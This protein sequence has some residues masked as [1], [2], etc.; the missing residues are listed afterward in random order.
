MKN[1]SIEQLHAEVSTAQKQALKDPYRYERTSEGLVEKG[2]PL[3]NSGKKT[4]PAAVRDLVN[5][6]FDKFPHQL[7]ILGLYYDAGFTV[8]E[9]A[10]MEDDIETN[11]ART[12][13][14][15]KA[16]LKKYLTAE[17]YDSIRWAIGDPTTLA[18][19]QPRFVNPFYNDFVEPQPVRTGMMLGSDGLI[20]WSDGA[21]S[22]KDHVPVN[23]P[24]QGLH[25]EPKDLPIPRHV[26]LDEQEEA[27]S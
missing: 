23:R 1:T 15:A 3:N 4:F 14:R 6:I 24:I 7:K 2:K 12:I 9:I 20:M 16:R 18:A 11:V 17:E 19:T 27:V 8:E 21:V 25:P 5:V 22:H 13:R 10:D 26:L